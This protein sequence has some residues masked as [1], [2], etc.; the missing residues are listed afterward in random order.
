MKK[1][2]KTM[3][4]NIRK[5]V[6]FKKGEEILHM[7]D[8][9]IAAGGTRLPVK[10]LFEKNEKTGKIEFY[11]ESISK[12]NGIGDLA[13]KQ[14]TQESVLLELLERKYPYELVLNSRKDK[15]MHGILSWEV[16]EKEEI[17]VDSSVFDELKQHILKNGFCS[18]EILEKNIAVMKSHRFTDEMIRQVLS[19]YRH[20]EKAANV[21]KTYYI[22]PDPTSKQASLFSECVLNALIGSATIYEGDKSVGKNMAA[23]TLAAIFNMP[24]YMITFNRTMC[25]DDVYGTKSTDNSASAHLT[26]E[27]AD[28]YVQYTTGMKDNLSRPKLSP[29]EEMKI[30]LENGYTEQ[31]VAEASGYSQSARKLKAAGI[32]D[33][34]VIQALKEKADGALFKDRELKKKILDDYFENHCKEMESG[35]DLQKKAAE[36]ELW[37]ARA[38]SVAIVQE[39]SCLV[40]WIRNGGVMCFNEMNMAEANFFASFANQIT[41]GSGFIDI[42]GYGRL[43]INPDCILIG[44]QNADY[45]GVCDQNDATMSRFGCIQFP[46]PNSIKNQLLA[47]V[48]KE[49]LAD[50]YFTECDKFYKE[51]LKAV[52]KGLVSNSC[53]NIRGMIRALEAVALIP[54]ATTLKRQITIHVINTCPKEDREDLQLQLQEIV[55]L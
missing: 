47:V 4:I 21:P 15:V 34:L 14:E 30:L 20:Y 8:E 38:A 40:E 7:L 52:H 28:A 44:T 46:Y 26:K 48:G 33:S 37:K 18:E 12:E 55:S 24:Y 3:G 5:T 35:N 17:V 42:P 22:D 2:M 50:Q 9:T 51:L 36:F 25:G 53:L 19:R 31:Y 6:R 41:D 11:A 39:E 1:N 16:A 43:E 54:G 29:E 32:D 23:E 49:K 45:T 27:L 13:P 10:I